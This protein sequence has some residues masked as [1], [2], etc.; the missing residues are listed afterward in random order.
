MKKIKIIISVLVLGIMF[1]YKVFAAGNMVVSTGSIS[2]TTGGST[3]F[4]VS[5][6]NAAGRVDISS[7]N[8]GVASVSTTSAFLDNSAV[9]VT[10][11]ARAAGSAVI[12]IRATDMTTYDDESLT[13]TSRA[14]SVNVSDPA[15]AP[16]PTPAPTPT[17]TPT[18]AS[19]PTPAATPTSNSTT[20]ASST[21]ENE[22]AAE[23]A[24]ED[25]KGV[26][27]D[28]KLTLESE[29]DDSKDEVDIPDTD[30]TS[31]NGA[32]IDGW[33]VA[34]IIEGLIIIGLG[35]WIFVLLNKNKK[36]SNSDIVGPQS[37]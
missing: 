33:M 22:P 16:A 23:E 3:T 11:T 29:E 4:T 13:G 1:P 31:D 36:P 15:P 6:N 26:V 30:G 37:F 34:A 14:V 18:P 17:P 12:M 7:S 9:T 8:G 25:P 35:V 27:L 32:T 28:E 21:G 10:V 24:K 19:N 20:P 2:L 5:A